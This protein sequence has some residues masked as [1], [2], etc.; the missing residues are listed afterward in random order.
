MNYTVSFSS[1]MWIGAVILAALSIMAVIK[2][3]HVK[4]EQNMVITL[5]FLSSP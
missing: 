4:L 5:S 3:H 1:V 2:N